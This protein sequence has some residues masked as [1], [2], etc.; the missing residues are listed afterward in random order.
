MAAENGV[1]PS[2]NKRGS[3]IRSVLHRFSGD[4]GR[5]QA[6]RL[7]DEVYQT[8]LGTGRRIR[9]NPEKYNI[10]QLPLQP[11][12]TF[13]PEIYQGRQLQTLEEATDEETLT[14]D[15]PYVA[16]GFISFDSEANAIL[17]TATGTINLGPFGPHAQRLLSTQLQDREMVLPVVLYEITDQEMRGQAGEQAAYLQT[18]P[19]WLQRQR[20]RFKQGQVL[21]EGTVEEVDN[22]ERDRIVI[23]T[24]NGRNRTPGGRISLVLDEGRP[25]Y[26]DGTNERPTTHE[27]VAVGDRVQ[28]TGEY[29][30][31][32][33][34]MT[35]PAVLQEFSPEHMLLYEKRRQEIEGRLHALELALT[36]DRRE[37]VTVDGNEWHLINQEARETV[38]RYLFAQLRREQHL[39]LA[40]QNEQMWKLIDSMDTQ[41][42]PMIFAEGD[43][44]HA[45]LDNYFA[46]MDKG[47]QM[48]RFTEAM[49]PVQ[50]LDEMMMAA[51]GDVYPPSLET[52]IGIIRD[53]QENFPQDAAATLIQ[54]VLLNREEQ[55]R[56]GKDASSAIHS[57]WETLPYLQEQGAS[58][59]T[60][61]LAHLIHAGGLRYADNPKEWENSSD[62]YQFMRMCLSELGS[63]V[64]ADKSYSDVNHQA[65]FALF[66]YYRDNIRLWPVHLPYELGK[67]PVLEQLL[68]DL[69]L[70]DMGRTWQQNQDLATID[71]AG[72]VYEQRDGI[73]EEDLGQLIGGLRSL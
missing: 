71:D 45:E 18:N 59:Q 26:D 65:L 51:A 50:L 41:A 38:A 70:V 13:D 21:V 9:G 25:V 3:P 64:Y 54:Y 29:V 1:D 37:S 61:W 36:D 40:E 28:V 30:G 12:A 15:V 57:L 63:T 72:D 48:Q 11:Q 73:T 35:G 46:K 6:A 34:F 2:R 20:L 10:G 33:L 49:T 53:Y 42:R 7:P 4:A 14:V 5:D 55:L 8:L 60:D 16:R 69:T 52:M 19:N 56:V 58:Y 27:P 39:L 32:Q 31:R 23:Q 62:L 43:S 24:R 47:S 22:D 44:R 67:E 17:E 66:P 68:R